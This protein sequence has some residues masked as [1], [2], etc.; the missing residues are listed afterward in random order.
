M[1]SRVNIV[2]MLTLVAKGSLLAGLDTSPTWRQAFGGKIDDYPAQGPNGDV[3]VIADDRALHSIDPL[4]GMS[5]WIYRPKGRLLNF[6]MVAPDGTI[7]IQNDRQELFAVTPGG[8]GRWKLLMQ[9]DT[10]A[11]PVAAPDGRLLIPLNGGRLL[12]VSRKGEI[13]WKRDESA[14]ASAAPVAV[15]NG[16]I[17][18]PL[19]DGR[20]IG[21]DIQGEIIA[22]LEGVGSASILALD[23]VGR[24]WVG[25]Y[26]G[27]LV[28]YA[29]DESPAE[30]VF[31][32]S[33]QAGRIAAIFTDKTSN[34]FVFYRDGTVL[35]V[36]DDGTIISKKQM[37]VIGGVPSLSRD[38]T[39]FAPASDGSIHV[40]EPSG[41][42]I[43]LR[44][45]TFL[46]DPLISEEGMLI[47][48]GG[49]WILYGWQTGSL[50]GEGWSQFRGGPRRS[51]TF[52][53]KR[54][55][56]DRGMA[57][58]DAGFVVR[59]QMALSDE[60]EDRLALISE[61]EGFNSE[62]QMYKELPWATL[63]L[64]DLA[65]AG[66]VKIS[67]S[68]PSSVVSYSLVRERAYRILGNSQDYRTKYFLQDCLQ[69]ES[70]TRALA[71]GF[72]ALG[73]L[74]SDW[75]ASSLRLIAKKYRAFPPGDDQLTLATA[76]ALF[77]LI[78]YNGGITH[79]IGYR[80]IEDLVRNASNETMRGKVLEHIWTPPP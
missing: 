50:P 54:V 36:A 8:T 1:I 49:E 10:A 47:A 14:N 68:R 32:I 30:L 29:I 42:E 9:A 70:D 73:N 39:I 67:T 25:G 24:L 60:I 34:G 52:P 33:S 35:S 21:L 66:T 57:R 61:I 63:L 71:V 78:Q 59:E 26:S 72:L 77:E 75:D 45:E 56:Y 64:Q 38:G 23:S 3:Y 12:C 43:I 18:V 65:T 58:E 20:I 31:E 79:P 27:K 16:T 44:D 40:V 13:L 62:Y 51:G 37:P 19:T 2:L 80:L 4:T 6:L 53:A 69:N 28:V 74:G 22:T 17:W 76:D 7:Y 48:G 41:R 46:A 11:L 55:I 15:S 5:H